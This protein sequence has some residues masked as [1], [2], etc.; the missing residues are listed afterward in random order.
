MAIDIIIKYNFIA[1]VAVISMLV[2]TVTGL[3]RLVPLFKL[4]S[5]PQVKLNNLN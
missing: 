5:E 3:D 4:P 2:L 1:M